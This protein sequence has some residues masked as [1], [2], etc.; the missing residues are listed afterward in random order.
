M[1]ASAKDDRITETSGLAVVVRTAD[2]QAVLACPSSESAGTD[3]GA[4]A[5]TAVVLPPV[6][7]QPPTAKM[8]TPKARVRANFVGFIRLAFLLTISLKPDSIPRWLKSWTF[9]SA[10]LTLR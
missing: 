9:V 4:G 10:S 5:E 2:K 3:P 8:V 1:P 7:K 6:S